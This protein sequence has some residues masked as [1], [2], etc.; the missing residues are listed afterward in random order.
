MRQISVL[1]VEMLNKESVEGSTTQDWL[2]QW[3]EGMVPRFLMMKFYFLLKTIDINNWNNKFTSCSC[4]CRED[5]TESMNFLLQI[6]CTLSLY[7]SLALSFSPAHSCSFML[8]CFYVSKHGHNI[9]CGQ[10]GLLQFHLAII[11]VTF[12][13]KFSH[14]WP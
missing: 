5:T 11:L 9:H 2:W 12:C 1:S 10:H 8:S 4:F 7:H 14:S 3:Q 6:W 13:H